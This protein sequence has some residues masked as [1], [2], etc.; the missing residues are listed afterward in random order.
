MNDLTSDNRTQIGTVTF[1]AALLLVAGYVWWASA[2]FPAE[3]QSWPRALAVALGISSMGVIG[4]TVYSTMR[5]KLNRD[6]RGGSEPQH[7]HEESVDSPT[8]ENNDTSVRWVSS[9]WT[10][11]GIAGFVVLAYLVSVI[12]AVPIYVLCALLLSKYRTRPLLLLGLTLGV[13]LTTYVLFGVATNMPIGS[14]ILFDIELP[15]L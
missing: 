2:G 10:L 4:T 15:Y 7:P 12:I 1:C 9:V 5:K 3:A 11:G 8:E 6:A 13:T 14:G